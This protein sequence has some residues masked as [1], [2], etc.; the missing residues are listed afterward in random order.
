[1]F[2]PQC[3][4]NQSEELKFCKSCGTNLHAVRQAVATPEA[5]QKFDWNKTWIAEMLLA[6]R[7]RKKCADDIE[8]RRGMTPEVKRYREIKAG[9]I[10][11]SIGVAL[12][13]FLKVFM[14]GLILSG[15]I[16]P[17][18]V[19][20]LNSIWVA[21]VLPFFIGLGLL[22]NGLF[23]SKGLVALSKQELPTSAD[24]LEKEA[25]RQQLRS[26]DTTEFISTDF[27]VT[28][29]TTKHLRASGQKQ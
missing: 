17:E 13:I 4:V 18:A 9:V 29:E 20:I 21:G 6:D 23:V 24:A 26:A 28:E 1:M 8:R 22:I 27:S 19:E 10:V 12:M 15:N 14:R 11:S 2:C 7:E 25:A 5:V 16:P 3:G